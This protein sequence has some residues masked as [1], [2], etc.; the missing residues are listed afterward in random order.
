MNK[1][2]KYKKQTFP[3]GECTPENILKL[4]VFYQEAAR[5][6][7]GLA[8]VVNIWIGPVW[9]QFMVATFSSPSFDLEPRE[10]RF[11]TVRTLPLIKSS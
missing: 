2:Q 9:K 4:C 8:L 11:S 10:K 7:G 1:N 3:S 6:R 5:Q